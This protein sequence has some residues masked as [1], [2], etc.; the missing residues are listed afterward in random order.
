MFHKV[1]IL[2]QLFT[3]TEA[4]INPFLQLELCGMFNV[5][6]KHV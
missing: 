4:K 1:G 5:L 2:A 3:I 6:Y